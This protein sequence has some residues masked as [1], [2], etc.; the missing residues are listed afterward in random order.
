MYLIHGVFSLCTHHE[1]NPK[2][3]GRIGYDRV[4]YRNEDN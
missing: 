3:A 4:F 1:H 2:G